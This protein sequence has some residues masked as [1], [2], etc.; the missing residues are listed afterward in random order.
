MPHAWRAPAKV[1]L[2]LHVIGRRTDGYHQLDS[3]IAFADIGDEVTAVPGT[4]LSLAVAGPFA[5]ALSEPPDSNLVCRA[6]R[7]LAA[8]LERAPEA[9]LSLVKNL[10]VASGIGG[11]SSDAAAALKALRG[12]WKAPLDDE[13]L[14]GIAAGL[15]ADV[16]VCVFART[17][18]LGGIGEE[19]AAAPPLP[20]TAVVLVNPNRPLATPAVFK[21]RQGP[22][23][24]PARFAEAAPDAKT[25]ARW[26]RLRRNDL[27]D[28]AIGLMPEI[29]D[30]LSMLDAVPGTLLARMSGS[31][32]TC[33]ALFAEPAEARAAAARIA[34]DRPDWWVAAGCF[35]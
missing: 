26:L 13:A 14:A 29:G 1:N 5:A 11:G 21:A 12:L 30:I 17:A 10:P 22:F 2:Y 4:S 33:F 24:T 32:A 34:A 3:L 6:A 27:T 9:T 8:R 31:G 20:K 15:G 7:Q 35:L 28:A 18:W 25:L 16:P 19:V 23:S